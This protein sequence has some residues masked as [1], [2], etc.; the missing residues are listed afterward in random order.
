MECVF[1]GPVLVKRGKICAGLD[2]PYK[3]DLINMSISGKQPRTGIG[4]LGKNHLLI[5]TV[6]G[7]AEGYSCGMTFRE[8][9]QL[10]IDYGCRL[11]YNLDGGG[12]VTMYQKGRIL[13][14]PS[15]GKE[16]RISD[17]IYIAKKSKSAAERGKE[18]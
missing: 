3:V 7:R 2:E 4:I 17:M 14:R 8:F 5:V 11:A 1:F 6:D 13:N 12:S 18:M 10:F 15:L 16:R 9:A